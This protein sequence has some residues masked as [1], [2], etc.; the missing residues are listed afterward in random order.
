MEMMENKEQPPH[1]PAP[2]FHRIDDSGSRGEEE[3]DWGDLSEW[4][5][6]FLKSRKGKTVVQNEEGGG[7]STTENSKSSEE[8]E[9]AA[10]SYCM[11]PLHCKM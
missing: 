11:S 2:L 5:F 8:S 1:R 7:Y 9:S 4:L 3:K 10:I 6:S